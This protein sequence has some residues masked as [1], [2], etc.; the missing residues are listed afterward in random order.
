MGAGRE[1]DAL[2]AEKVM[3]IP[4]VGWARAHWCVDEWSILGDNDEP[5]ENEARHP[6]YAAHCICNILDSLVPI[7]E[8]TTEARFIDATRQLLIDMTRAENARLTCGHHRGCLE[9]VTHYSTDYNAV[10]QVVE[11]MRKRRRPLHLQES[12]GNYCAEFDKDGSAYWT[13]KN[14]SSAPTAPHAIC[15]AALKAVEAS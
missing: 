11:V 5:Q 8:D 6:V 10:F 4:V 12:L 1:L 13:D 14:Y 7:D 3:G 2:I 9:P 15:L